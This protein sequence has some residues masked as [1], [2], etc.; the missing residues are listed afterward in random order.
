MNYIAADATFVKKQIANLIEA[1]PEIQDDEELLA[2]ML[3][4]ETDLHRVI[5]KAVSKKLDAK[6][7][8]QALKAREA[9]MKERR[10]RFERQDELFTALISQMMEIAGLKKLAL[11]EATVS[12]TSP[13]DSVE[14]LD[15]DALPQGFFKVERKA[16]SKEI[17]AAIKAG[18][19]IPGAALRTGES[20]LMVR[21][22]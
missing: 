18:E 1:Y 2:D 20:G 4:G 21:T 7:M 12:M 3:E 6:T 14:I 8:V 11:P 13:R 16:L 10:S 17:L 15:I 9:D 19:A 22:K 5:S